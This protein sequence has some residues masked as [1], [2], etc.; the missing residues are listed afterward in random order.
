MDEWPRRDLDS[1]AAACADQVF[2]ELP[3]LTTVALCT[4]DLPLAES[5]AL[6]DFAIAE[7]D[8]SIT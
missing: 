2:H 8:I 4:E 3:R 1:K 7:V 6:N 5:D